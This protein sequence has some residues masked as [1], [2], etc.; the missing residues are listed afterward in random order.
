MELEYPIRS[1]Y[2]L[3]FEDICRQS[4]K[5]TVRN[6]YKSSVYVG[7]QGTIISALKYY[8][9]WNTEEKVSYIGTRLVLL[10]A[11]KIYY[12]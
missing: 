10:S 5:S 1:I 9:T 4:L 6:R 8:H 7:E 12:M 11:R 3:R 2:Y